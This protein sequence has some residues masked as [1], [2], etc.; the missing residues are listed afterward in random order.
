[1]E[2]H[3]DSCRAAVPCTAHADCPIV[4]APDLCTRKVSFQDY[5]YVRTSTEVSWS[6]CLERLVT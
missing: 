1:M 6:S 4:R 2:V 5:S 3:A